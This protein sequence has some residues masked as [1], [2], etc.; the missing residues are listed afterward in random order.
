MS[1]IPRLHPQHIEADFLSRG[2][3]DPNQSPLSLTQLNI[4]NRVQSLNPLAVEKI[5]DPEGTK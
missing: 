4:E 1:F 3:L 2:P 5:L